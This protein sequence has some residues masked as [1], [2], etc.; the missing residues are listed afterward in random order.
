M[1]PLGRARSRVDAQPSVIL[2][3]GEREMGLP[4]GCRRAGVKSCPLGTGKIESPQ[5]I[6]KGEGSRERTE[7][8][9]QVA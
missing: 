4:E 6:P 1:V 8:T 7:S 9:T 3:E 5:A 2:S